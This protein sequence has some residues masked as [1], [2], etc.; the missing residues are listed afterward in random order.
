MNA[1]DRTLSALG[2]AG[3][4]RD[5]PLS[6][7]GAWP[8][9]S[10]LLVGDRLLPLERAVHADR[11]PVLAVG[12]NA[13]PGQLRHKMA[14]CGV[15]SPV[16]MVRSRVH[17]LDVGVSA[18]VSL[19]GYVAASP[20]CAPEAVRDL[21]VIWLDAEQLAVVDASEGT[22][23][24]HGNYRRAWLPAPDV[25]VAPEGGAAL[26]GVYVYLNRH[27]VLHD[28]SGAPRSHPGQRELLAELLLNSARLREL[29]GVTPEEFS[30]RARAD[31]ALCA[32]GTR[33]L[34][35]EK[36]VTASG[37]ERYADSP[38]TGATGPGGP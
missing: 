1:Q 13:C 32:R 24:P 19:M 12:S 26:P 2:L 16:P 21:F 20:V 15:S 31:A 33:L 4:P 22:P 11:V 10:G 8:R 28:G 36:L 29:F 5:D 9:E 17:G 27:G 18:H 7:P 30:A 23:L 34:A 38:Q 3:V 37:L 35:E 25:R 6:Y 14:A